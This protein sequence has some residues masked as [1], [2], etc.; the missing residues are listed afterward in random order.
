MKGKSFCTAARIAV[1]TIIGNLA[2]VA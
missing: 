2:Q 1:M